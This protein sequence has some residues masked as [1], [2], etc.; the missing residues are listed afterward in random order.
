M[1]VIATIGFLPFIGLALLNIAM[2]RPGAPRLNQVIENYMARYPVIAAALACF[3]G[4]LAGHI[5]WATGPNPPKPFAD[6][7]LLWIALGVGFAIGGFGAGALALLGSLLK[8]LTCPTPSTILATPARTVG[9]GEQLVLRVRAHCP[10]ND[11]ELEV[12][13]GEEYSVTASGEWWDLIFRSDAGGY[14]PP[15]WS[16]L[17]TL[18]QG[19]R[20]L[21]TQP[22]FV[23]GAQLLHERGQSFP[24]GPSGNL[25]MSSNGRLILFANDVK[26]FYWNNFGS[27]SVTIRRV[28]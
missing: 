17:Q 26:G 5:F 24:V 14:Q 2:T 13:Q 15:S 7:R 20:R 12:K 10:W 21:P 18:L 19:E 28:A 25:R 22:W 4:A 8:P 23:L 1:A 27:I 11:T 3:V 9:V 16:F 6:T